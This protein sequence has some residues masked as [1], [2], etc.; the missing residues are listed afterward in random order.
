MWN[1]S[2]YSVYDNESY[3]PEYSY[4]DEYDDEDSPRFNERNAAYLDR[5]NRS[6]WADADRLRAEQ[7]KRNLSQRLD[8][9]DNAWRAMNRFNPRLSDD[10][11]RTIHSN[12]FEFSSSWTF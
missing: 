12:Q 1:D 8:Y 2:D 9:L 11:K 6:R 3:D 5:V 10:A 4:D 7:A